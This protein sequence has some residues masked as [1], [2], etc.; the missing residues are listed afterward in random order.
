M[1]QSTANDSADLY[2]ATFVSKP[3]GREMIFAEIDDL[4]VGKVL[5]VN[6]GESLSLQLHNQ[7][8]ETICVISGRGRLEFGTD[9]AALE[10]TAFGTGDAV[11]LPAGVLHRL[12]ADEELV[13]AEVSTAFSGW[14]EDVVRLDDRY[15]RSGTT[16]P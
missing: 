9:P 5:F 10:S 12:I 16:A 7:K 15:G 13:L 14:R 2:P 8:T 6:A 1:N 11:H 3:W 4:Y